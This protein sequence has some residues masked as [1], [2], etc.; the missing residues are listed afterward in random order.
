MT[1]GPMVRDIITIAIA[2][3]T[4]NYLKKQTAGKLILEWLD[5]Y[6]DQE[7]VRE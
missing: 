4:N 1:E 2:E 3:D 6:S 5:S 7:A